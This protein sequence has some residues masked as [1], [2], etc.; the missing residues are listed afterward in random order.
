VTSDTVG[1]MEIQTIA[2][3][4]NSDIYST[5]LKKYTPCRSALDYEINDWESYLEN[6]SFTEPIYF[7]RD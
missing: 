1:A 7:E 2:V 5:G 3:A 4:Y 6:Q